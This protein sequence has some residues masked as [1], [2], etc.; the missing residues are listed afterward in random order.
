V[1]QVAFCLHVLHVL[2]GCQALNIMHVMRMHRIIP[3]YAACLAIPFFTKLPHKW[4]DIRQKL[5]KAKCALI[6]SPHLPKT[7]IL[8]RIQRHILHIHIYYVYYI[9]TYIFY[10]YIYT[11]TYT[12]TRTRVGK[13]RFNCSYGKT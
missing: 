6:F 10:I 5:L 2:G 11:Y 7:F 3:S 9:Y 4:H 12:H 8:T 13:S 1:H